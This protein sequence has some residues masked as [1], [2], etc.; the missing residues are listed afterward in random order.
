MAHNFLIAATLSHFRRLFSLPNLL[1]WVKPFAVHNPGEP[2]IVVETD[3]YMFTLERDVTRV[4]TN[5]VSTINLEHMKT[6]VLM[7]KM[8]G[9][10]FKEEGIHRE[11][12]LIWKNGVK[13]TFSVNHLGHKWFAL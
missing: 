13:N 2:P 8:F 11:L 4:D 10:P 5:Q 12:T 1:S 3:N 7:R 6:N 9:K